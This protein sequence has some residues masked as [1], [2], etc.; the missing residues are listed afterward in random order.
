[1][2]FEKIVVGLLLLIIKYLIG[3]KIGLSNRQ[4]EDMVPYGVLDEAIQF[5]GTT[6][7]Q[8]P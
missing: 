8:K 3:Q 7:E 5:V 1:M 6:T 4:I 2:N